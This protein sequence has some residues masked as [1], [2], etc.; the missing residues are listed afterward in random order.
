M[1]FKLVVLVYFKNYD[2]LVI[3]NLIKSI[4]YIKRSKFRENI[5]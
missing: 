1:T 5:S 4:G 2:I 3:V